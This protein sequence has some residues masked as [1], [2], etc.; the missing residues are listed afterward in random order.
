MMRTAGS[1][2]TLLAILIVACQPAAGAP[3]HAPASQTASEASAGRQ[4]TTSPSSA[5]TPVASRVPASA[6][7]APLQPPVMLSVGSLGS[8]GDLPF[9]VALE[10][11]YFQEEG[12]QI[13]VVDFRNSTEMTPPLA[14]GQL[15]IGLGG[16]NAALF[17]SVTQGI[18]LKIVANNVYTDKSAGWMVRADLLDSRQVT[19][20]QDLKGLVF[21][22]G[23]TGSIIDVELDR[24]LEEGKITRDD[25]E[26]RQVAYPDQ[27]V[28]FANKFIDVAYVF[29][30]TRTRLIDQGLARVWKSSG[31]IYPNHES[32]VLVYGP[33]MDSK[34]EAGR[35]FMYGYLRGIREHKEQGLER[36]D[37]QIIR[38]ATER[39]SIKD[40]ELWQKG[41]PLRVGDR[42]IAAYPSCG[43]CYFCAVTKQPVL[44]PKVVSYGRVRC[45][46]PPFLLG[47]CAEYHYVP[48]GCDVIRVPSN[49]SSP[50]AASAACALR[51]V[52]CA[53]EKLGTIASHETVLIQGAG[54]VGL[55]AAAVARQRG[56]RK[57]LVIGAPGRRLEVARA[58]GAD[59]VLDL[60]VHTDAAV[61]L[62]WA[63]EHTDG[64][65]ADIVMQCATA[66]AIP[67]GLELIR[68][69]GRYLSI[70]MSRGTITIPA[71][72]LSLKALQ[73]IGVFMAEG[74]H[75]YQAID[76]LANQRSIPFERVLTGRF[77]LARVTEA[78]RAME[79]FQEVK[80]VILPNPLPTY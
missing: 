77:E 28:A 48:P 50:L 27:V 1:L 69:G 63:R 32:V 5:P 74:R 54:P 6:A 17:N 80:A 62:Q 9:Y 42:I 22:L 52:M 66:A 70:G 56:A 51:T 19:G 39:T 2:A 38:I 47:G 78:L 14:A 73:V 4:N 79:T 18:S 31:E 64:R 34:Q 43:H 8:G 71:A 30:P 58:W 26:L 44:C 59:D 49:V 65:G 68:R 37:P 46:R 29:E 40:P 75:F 3:A 60:D 23:S 53:V 12:L 45:D 36:R 61:R 24:I 16:V 13:N 11:G 20:A 21:G 55:Y 33:S 15:D 10:Q 72:T 35:R 57:V 41:E 67:E 7:P 25:I 76:F